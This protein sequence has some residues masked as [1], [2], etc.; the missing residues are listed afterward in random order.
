MKIFKVTSFLFSLLLLAS[1]EIVQETHFNADGSGTYSLGFDMSEM[2]KMGL[3]SEEDFTSQQID[4]LLVFADY[5]E[6]K[7]DSIAKLSQE[8]Q[9]KIKE[10]EPFS[11]SMKSDTVTNTLEMKLKYDFKDQEDLLAFG[12]KLKGQNFDELS[13]FSGVL[14]TGKSAD[15]EDGEEGKAESAFPDFNTSFITSF[16]RE[17]F[18]L[19]ITQ[20]ALEKQEKEKDTTIT[21]DSPMVELVRFKNRYTFPYKVKAVSNKN[22]RVLSD[23]KGIEISGNLFEITNNPRFFDM[24]VAFEGE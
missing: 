9:D 2:M 3:S 4:T 24:D 10:L 18:S 22:A 12:D 1:C 20:E 8:D 15:I 13:M 11:L 21:A 14:S 5:I 19:R 23:F 6:L 7:K 17:G 16:S